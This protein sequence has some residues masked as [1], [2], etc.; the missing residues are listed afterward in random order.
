ML[1]YELLVFQ[2][3]PLFY[4]FKGVFAYTQY[5]PC[6]SKNSTT[7]CKNQKPLGE[8]GYGHCHRLGMDNAISNRGKGRNP[9]QPLPEIN[10]RPCSDLCSGISPQ[11]PISFAAASLPWGWQRGRA[12]PQQ[13]PVV[14]KDLSIILKQETEGSCRTWLLGCKSLTTPS[15][16][17]STP[18]HYISSRTSE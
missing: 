16:H 3:R 4:C 17:Y 6:S 14:G 1:N 18:S 13:Q 2:P 12:E 9:K 11:F 10:L 7:L 8:A 15:S 5:L